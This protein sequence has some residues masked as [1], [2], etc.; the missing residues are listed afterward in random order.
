MLLTF[1]EGV[2]T[3]SREEI[4]SGAETEEKAIQRPHWNPPHI[5]SL[6]SDTIIDAKKFLLKGA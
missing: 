2:T 1:L 4:Q 5:Q 3:Y 6:N